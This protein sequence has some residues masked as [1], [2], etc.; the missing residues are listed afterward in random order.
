MGA[1]WEHCAG[2]GGGK[3]SQALNTVGPL[4]LGPPTKLAE[5]GITVQP[6]GVSFEDTR[7]SPKDRRAH[8]AL[9]ETSAI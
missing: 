8:T 3:P 5:R 1:L 2:E 6:H 4:S 9:R 7:R